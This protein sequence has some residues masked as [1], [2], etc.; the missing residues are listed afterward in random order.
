MKITLVKLGGIGDIVQL[1]IALFAFK[2]KFPAVKVSWITSQS[3]AALIEAFGIADQVIAIDDKKIFFGNP[4]NRVIHLFLAALKITKLSYSNQKIVTAYVDWRYRLLT[5]CMFWIPSIDFPQKQFNP[6]VQSRNRIYEYWRLLHSSNA[7]PETDLNVAKAT[8]DF[9]HSFISEYEPLQNLS[10]LDKNT[11]VVLVPG[12]AKNILRDDGLR[13]WPISHYVELAKKLIEQNETV[14]IAGGPEDQWVRDDFMGLP[15]VDLVGKTSLLEL[16]HLLN[17]SKLTVVHDTGPMHLACLTQAPMIA[18]FGP[19]P[20]NAILPLGRT[21]T[22]GIQ[23]GNQVACSPCYDG[24]NYADCHDAVCMKSIS[25]D[26]V[27]QSI[28]ELI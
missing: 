8:L 11:Y 7:Y 17:D 6:M 3:N 5:A 2:K 9:G 23:L 19:T 12:G 25:V 20:M 10:G 27:M 24:K 26:S 18:L 21:R 28:R 4:L 16:I 1:A 14:L 13:R 22:V 15:V